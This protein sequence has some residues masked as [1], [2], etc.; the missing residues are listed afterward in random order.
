MN[1]QEKMRKLGRGMVSYA[2]LLMVFQIIFTQGFML[3]EVP[4]GS[5]AATIKP[6]DHIISTR[7]DIGEEDIE[8]YDVLIFTLP[9]NPEMTYLKRVV[10]L[11]GEKIEVKNGKVYADGM[12]LDNS[13]TKGPQNRRGD[14]T[15]VVPEGCYFFLGDNRNNSKD[16]RFWKEKYVPAA[17]IQAKARFVFFPFRDASWL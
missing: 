16:S 10:G 5:M 15:Y 6:G 4:T 12:E 11:P 13:F 17:N 1:E 7:F 9:D 3:S 14:G 2:V 8:R